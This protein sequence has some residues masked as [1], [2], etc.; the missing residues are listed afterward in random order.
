[1]G[2]IRSSWI[3]FI[4]EGK[5]RSFLEERP[6]GGEACRPKIEAGGSGGAQRRDENGVRSF[7]TKGNKRYG[8]SLNRNLQ[9][10]GESVLRGIRWKQ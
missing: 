6:E 8:G 10:G 2:V 9:D 1:M 3:N 4:G 5:R 7:G